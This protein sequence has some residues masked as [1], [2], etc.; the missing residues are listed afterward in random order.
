VL[1]L[2]ELEIDPPLDDHVF[3]VEVPPDATPLTLEEL[4]RSGPLGEQSTEA[5]E[6]TE[7]FHHGGAEARRRTE[8]T[9]WPV[10]GVNIARQLVRSARRE[11][12]RETWSGRRPLA[13][14][15]T[16]H[17]ISDTQ[18]PRHLNRACVSEISRSVSARSAARPLILR[19]SLCPRVS[20][21]AFV[22]DLRLL[23]SLTPIDT[24]SSRSA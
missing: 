23:L 3:D 9:S 21:V 10:A 4:R 11:S 5:A 19:A 13:A 20:V 15:E 16:E 22:R 12:F 7:R 18:A 6:S 1:R 2:S 8:I 24:V 17:E 14:V